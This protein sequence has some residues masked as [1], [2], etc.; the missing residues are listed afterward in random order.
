MPKF[1]VILDLDNT[2][3]PFRENLTQL[4]QKHFVG[5]DLMKDYVHSKHYLNGSFFEWAFRTGYGKLNKLPSWSQNLRELGNTRLFTHGKP[6]DG[7]Q[8]LTDKISSLDG[9][10]FI[11]T[12]R[13]TIDS[14]DIYFDNGFEKTKQWLANYNIK[15]HRLIFTQKKVETMRKLEQEYNLPILISLE[16]AKENAV[17]MAQAGF[18]TLLLEK[19]YN[20]I[21]SDSLAQELISNGKLILVK[22]LHEAREKLEEIAHKFEN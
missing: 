19:T 22:D 3:Y 17:Q 9:L 21:N 2:L 15:H 13:G 20:N 12:H 16:D 10:V 5:K 4:M 14:P 7:A 1:Q 6:Y 18:T 11:L 8:E